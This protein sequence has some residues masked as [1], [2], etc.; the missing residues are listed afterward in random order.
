ADA[1]KQR[2]QA[3]SSQSKFLSSLSTQVAGK[4]NTTLGT[5]ISLEAL[6]DNDSSDPASRE[7]PYVPAAERTLYA[8]LKW[9]EPQTV[10]AKGGRD[11]ALACTSHA[12][13]CRVTR[14]L[15]R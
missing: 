6:P 5:L 14:L 2:N 7:R 8:S 13:R 9:L 4:G 11:G 3:L 1:L 15:A 12:T 10:L